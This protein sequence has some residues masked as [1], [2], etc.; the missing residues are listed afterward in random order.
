MRR[1]NY[2]S[3][4]LDCD[5]GTRC[6]IEGF[7]SSICHS[8]IFY[9]RDECTFIDKCSE[10]W[11]NV[12]AKMEMDMTEEQKALLGVVTHDQAFD[13]KWYWWEEHKI[14]NNV[15][16]MC[17]KYFANAINIDE[18]LYMDIY[19]NMFRRYNLFTVTCVTFAG[20]MCGFI[21]FILCFHFIK[22]CCDKINQR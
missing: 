13:R 12:T 16:R 11:I 4:Y 10:K 2:F 22:K 15:A 5:N 3:S 17:V 19:A 6:F 21:F 8:L 7:P 20:F 18:E 14:R 1:L 9:F